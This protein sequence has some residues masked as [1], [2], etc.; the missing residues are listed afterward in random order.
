M[1]IESK[2]SPSESGGRKAT[3]SGS[4]PDVHRIVVVGGGAGGLSLVS[5][6]ARKFKRNAQLEVMLVDQNSTHLWKPLLHEVATGSL[7]GNHDEV[8]YVSLAR[9][10]GFRFMLGK[11]ANVDADAKRITVTM[12]F[13]DAELPSRDRTIEYDQLVLAI[14]SLSNDFGIPGVAENAILLDSRLQ[15]E[16]FHKRFIAHLHR[17][18]SQRS[19]DKP[20]L[21][22]VIVG[23]GATGVE[24]AADLH[25]VASQLEDFGF[26]AFSPEKLKI[27]VLEA[28]PRL[29]AQLPERISSSV[30]KELRSLGVE[31]HTSMMVTEIT[32]DEVR[33]REG[34]PFAADLSVWAAGIRAPGVL[35][36][37]GLETDGLGRVVTT[38]SLNVVSYPGVFVIGDCGHCPMGEA[39][40]EGDV[41]VVP[42]RAQSA[43]QM[44]G[45]A[46]KNIINQYKGK[47]LKTF[48]Y[49]DYGSLVSLSEYSTVGN[50]MGNLMKG[51]LFIE[52]ALARL[53]YRMLYRRHQSDVHGLF[54]TMLI[55]IGDRIHR[56][57]HS[58]LKLH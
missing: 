6:L 1:T 31:V 18:N 9:K 37:S 5:R 20:V 49:N 52:G 3:R 57:T 7:D 28:G 11:L 14:G 47:P 2:H 12:D 35:K 22:V 21:S 38:R 30:I 17:I 19:E 10:Y 8:S 13:G 36:E 23:G 54:S 44:A 15:A 16:Q 48:T 56:A 34:E 27:S 45:V 4:D 51:S 25:S 58:H 24:L 55:M 33:S 53:V 50:L 26:K 40:A 46:Y 39:D 42:P 29:L 43:H 32:P 41:A